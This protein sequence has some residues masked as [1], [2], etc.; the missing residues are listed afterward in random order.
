MMVKK[1]LVI[2]VVALLATV[3]GAVGQF[4]IGL[5]GGARMGQFGDD[6]FSPFNYEEMSYRAGL[7]LSYQWLGTSRI[8]LDI[9]GAYGK[10]TTAVSDQFT[11]DL[12]N[13][14]VSLGYKTKVADLS[15]NIGLWVGGEARSD[16]ELDLYYPAGSTLTTVS[17]TYLF[18]HTLRPEVTAE[19]M[20]GAHQFNLDLSMSLFGFVA[21]PPYNIMP[22]YGEYD[23]PIMDYFWNELG[24]A[25][26]MFLDSYFDYN[27]GLSYHFMLG[28]VVDF[29]L[30]Y[31][32]SYKYSKVAEPL[33]IVRNTLSF[34]IG[35]S[36]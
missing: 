25:E 6:T 1:G 13:A 32:F 9:S 36:L 20:L 3:Q 16:L 15:S 17:Y 22:Q 24:S 19:W 30:K 12:Y 35:I 34:S 2:V 31:D 7:N 11:T 26:F 10:L 21:R 5:E 27:V 14:K 8:D 4:R 18:A 28:S 29:G 23:I 33:T